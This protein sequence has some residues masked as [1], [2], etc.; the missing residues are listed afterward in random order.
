MLKD[1]LDNTDKYFSE[2]SGENL[3][4][5]RHTPR[6]NGLIYNGTGAANWALNNVYSKEDYEGNDCTN[7]VSK[8]LCFGGGM[9]QDFRYNWYQGSM[10][11]IRVNELYEYL[12][13]ITGYCSNYYP[14]WYAVP[15]DVIQLYNK[16]KQTFS[17]SLIVTKKVGSGNVYV[18][19]HSNA[20]LNVPLTNYL[21]NGIYSDDRLLSFIV[22]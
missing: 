12:S 17:H 21:T 11:W 10:R 1:K 22:S 19:A 18:S 16:N 8:A 5:Q 2:P 20:A 4:N 7:F 3:N 15:G 13:P 14:N 9:K 6:L